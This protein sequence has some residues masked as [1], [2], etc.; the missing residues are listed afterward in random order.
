MD[1]SQKANTII[2]SS[3]GLAT[4]AAVIP[5]PVADTVAISGIQIGMVVSLGANYGEVISKS[6]AKSLLGVFLAAKVGEWIASLAKAIPG[7]G[8]LVGGGAQML[9]AGTITLSLGKAVKSIL[10]NNQELSTENLKKAKDGLDKK[11]IAEE[12][13]ILKD[14]IKKTR[15][16][17]KSIA[18]TAFP[19]SF[20][21]EVVFSF[22]LEDINEA[23]LRITTVDGEIVYQGEVPT[24]S[25]S[26]TIDTEELDEGT[27]LAYLECDEL[28][29]IGIEIEKED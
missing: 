4:A 16:A 11:E 21:D 10:E 7:L 1:Q 12:A 24:S 22:N 27:Y 18:F 14:K 6:F 13:K 20:S 19:E 2:N 28:L 25:D 9:I 26:E 5:I 3:T 17:Q 23:S 29:P 15:A 8:T